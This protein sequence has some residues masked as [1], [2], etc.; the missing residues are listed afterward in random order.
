MPTSIEWV[1]L[2]GGVIMWWAILYNGEKNEFDNANKRFPYKKWVANWRYKRL[3]DIIAHF[4]VSIVFLIM[5]V[6]NLQKWLGNT[7]SVPQGMD[8]IGAAVFIGFTGSIIAQALIMLAKK[9]GFIRSYD[10]ITKDLD[11]E[12]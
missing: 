11:L 7:M 2:L 5:G 10:Q 9:A 4:I 3:D 12:D 6:E 8:E 1:S